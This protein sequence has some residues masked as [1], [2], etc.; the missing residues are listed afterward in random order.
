MLLLGRPE[1]SYLH[2]RRSA[3]IS[4]S[5]AIESV[6]PRMDLIGAVA[7]VLC[8][9]AVGTNN[10]F[11]SALPMYMRRSLLRPSARA[12]ERCSALRQ[13]SP[14]SRFYGIFLR[15]RSANMPAMTKASPPGEKRQKGSL[16]GCSRSL[17]RN[18]ARRL[19]LRFRKS[20]KRW[21]L[22]EANVSSS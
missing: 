18:R 22:W 1:I 20:K 7:R 4:S 9:L 2:F 16:L 19:F 13:P 12:S 17:T 15:F 10:A 3:T 14:P 11:M 6:R 5:S 21:L 8:A